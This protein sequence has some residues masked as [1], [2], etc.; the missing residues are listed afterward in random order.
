[1]IRPALRTVLPLLVFMLLLTPLQAQQLFRA[2]RSFTVSASSGATGIAVGDF[3]NDGIPDVVVASFGTTTTNNLAVLLGKSNGTLGAPLILTAG[4]GPMSVA[5]GDFN[6][7]KNLDIAVLDSY[8][9]Q[10]VWVLLGNGNGTFQPAVGYTAGQATASLLPQAIIAG[11]F[12]GDHH[13]DLAVISGNGISNSG[14]AVMLGFGNGAFGAAT[15]YN[16]LQNSV[17]LATG[18]FNGDGKLDLATSGSTGGSLLLGNGD[19]TFQAALNVSGANGSAITVR[20]YNGDHNLDIAVASSSN[21]NVSFGNGDGTFQPPVSYLNVSF[22]TNTIGT[23]DLN[24]DG[25]PDLVVGN[26]DNTINVLFNKGDGTFP[27][28][29]SYVAGFGPVSVAFGD[30]NKDGHP[31]VVTANPG[32]PRAGSTVSVLLNQGTGTLVAAQN[33]NMSTVS[34]VA[35][36]DFNND[37]RQDMAVVSGGST[38]TILLGNGNGTFG[39]QK[40]V[41]V[42]GQL[43]S[44]ASADFNHDGKSDLAVLSNGNLTLLLGNGDGT[45]HTGATYVVPSGA[46]VTVADFNADGIADLAVGAP[47]AVE[48]LLGNGDG[49][50]R[51][52]VSYGFTSGGSL[53]VVGDFNNDLKLDI[54]A[55]ASG[56]GN[57]SLLLGNGDGTFQAAQKIPTA[58]ASYGAAAGD[59]NGD[60]KLDLAFDGAVILGNG[61]GTFGKQVHYS[62]GVGASGL[63][64][65]DFNGDGKL[66]IAVANNGG[67]YQN[68]GDVL[69][70][71]GNGDGTFQKPQTYA[72]NLSPNNLALCDLDGDGSPDLVSLDFQ[73]TVFL[74]TR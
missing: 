39:S 53:L 58:P 26:G 7:D 36:G 72:S 15:F 4:E 28:T 21:V 5:V 25:K 67:S 12:N 40:S 41:A 29:R 44:I 3:N 57:A 19:G 54:V 24:H 62:T 23:V 49:T 63:V 22:G 32:F 8:G 73:L 59:F 65:A 56:H 61:D 38:V 69:V 60:G 55:V 31:D 51:G 48:I 66:D 42:G 64:V 33:L 45:F 43:I 74:N 18:D 6:G 20:D 17:S 71:L 68:V 52:P 70:S 11:D 47:A 14:I 46:T 30:F 10:N 34:G 13:L 35:L 37:G 50:F 1:M 16:T 2:A 9:T 27:T